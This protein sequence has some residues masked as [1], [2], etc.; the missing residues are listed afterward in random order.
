MSILLLAS[1]YNSDFHPSHYTRFIGAILLD[2]Q[3]RTLK[4]KSDFEMM[5]ILTNLSHDALRFVT[6]LKISTLFVDETE[7][8]IIENYVEKAND[9]RLFELYHNASG[10]N[11]KAEKRLENLAAKISLTGH[12]YLR[13]KELDLDNCS[14][15]KVKN[16]KGVSQEMYSESRSEK[17][18]ITS[19]LR[20]FPH[21]EE[22]EV[23]YDMYRIGYY[24]LHFTPKLRVL[25][26]AGQWPY[27]QIIACCYKEEI[28]DLVT[29]EGSTIE[30][31]APDANTMLFPYFRN[32]IL[33]S[34]TISNILF[35]KPIRCVFGRF[36]IENRYQ[37]CSS[38]LEL[39][40]Q[41]TCGFEGIN[42]YV[43]TFPNLEILTL[44]YPFEDFTFPENLRILCV[45]GRL[46]DIVLS[47]YMISQIGKLE[48]YT[49]LPNN[50]KLN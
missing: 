33:K 36:K 13:G 2:F 42:R 26:F 22:L 44:L 48:K 39:S 6:T 23:H 34:G 38:V 24:C 7:M 45:R 20:R 4:T 18:M 15:L 46:E 8:D 1:K 16:L 19:L 31:A 32:L 27:V 50:Y 47:D 12:V 37:A 17:A 11:L 41:Y 25:R 49:E 43:E 30:T 9:I 3:A 21:V 10:K 14:Q 28:S 29:L 40:H 5:K 35:F